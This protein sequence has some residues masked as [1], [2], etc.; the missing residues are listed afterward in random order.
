MLSTSVLMVYYL[1]L[2]K[3]SKPIIALFIIIYLTIEVSFLIANLVK[4]PHGGWVTVVI[5]AVLVSV[6]Y[7][8]LR[9]F[10]I[11]RRLTEYVRLDKYI[12]SLK[13]LSEDGSI[14]KYATHLIYMTS[15]EHK[16]EI[17]SKI[18]YSIFQ[19][20]PKRA[21]IYWF[22]HVHITDEPH[23]LEYKVAHIAPNDVVRVDFRLGFR[24]EQRINLYF[25]K[26]VENLVM[27]KEV[28]IT[29]R[30]ESLNRQNIIG[31]FRFVVLEKYLS[32]DNE[33]PL[34]EK[35]IMKGYFNLKDLIPSEDKWFGL[36][37]SSV[38]IEK[39]PMVINPVHDIELKRIE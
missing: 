26:V 28:D 5:G 31:D 21:D 20:R 19:K 35:L 9:A 30:Y 25:R 15:A 4:F 16:N 24:V 18:I 39:V 6:M 10:Y 37:T 11:K 8:W 36:D 1:Y 22:L 3:I 29:S 14:P 12:E 27:N 23:T 2:K 38:K 34:N 7:I 33:L 13:E 17:E 32:A